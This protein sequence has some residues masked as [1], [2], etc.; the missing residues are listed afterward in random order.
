MERWHLEHRTFGLV[1]VLVGTHDELRG[2]DPDFPVEAESKES[3]EGE[4]GKKGKKR[5]GDEPQELQEA[6]KALMKRVHTSV[7]RLGA[8]KLL[9]RPLDIL[10]SAAQQRPF[11]VRI[12]GYVIARFPD[13]REVKIDLSRKSDAEKGQ[14][15]SPFKTGKKDARGY[16][17]KDTV[18]K[19]YLK[20]EV[21][22]LGAWLRMVSVHAGGEVLE[23]EAPAGSRGH[24]RLQEMEESPFKRWFYPLVAGLGKSGW[25]LFCLV[26]LPLLGRILDPILELLGL[27]LRPVIEWLAQ[28]IPD[29]HIE[30][31]WPEIHLPRI[32]WPHI[33]W[34]EIPWPDWHLP[35]FELPWIVQLALDYPKVWMPIVAGVAIG[36][37]SVRN[38]RKSRR[39][40]LQ[41]ERERFAHALRAL[42]QQR[43]QQVGEG[44]A[45]E[46][47]NEVK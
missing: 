18:T 4:K 23:L 1:E 16:H 5:S 45:S 29:W 42:E 41:W 39:R 25:A 12:D 37:V 2:V 43:G 3:E 26:I 14:A 46:R 40:K 10:E 15:D 32:P 44:L 11:L 36:V 24:K 33:D 27:L 34:P 8:A 31:P 38:N 19:P 21:A 28:F 7:D 35:Q 17:F 22:G 6:K 47:R 13:L 20:V 9:A 30:I